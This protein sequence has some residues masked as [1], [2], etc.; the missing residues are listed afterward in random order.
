M[1]KTPTIDYD[2]LVQNALKRV[3]RDVMKSVAEHGMPDEHHF[4]ITF[5]TNHPKV[6]CPTYITEEHPEEI[7]IILQHE[8]EDLQ[9]FDDHFKVTLG[10]D[11]QDEE[12]TVPFDSIICFVD[13]YVKFG[14]H[15]DDPVSPTPAW[16]ES[17]SEEL[18]D[19]FRDNV[20]NLEDFRRTKK[21]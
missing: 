7:T 4:L 3:I 2:I 20:V 8:Y 6:H 21:D 12:L 16:D 11:E 13:P 18:Q 15:F 19:G 9:V 1:G 17:N 10:F 5:A 14:L